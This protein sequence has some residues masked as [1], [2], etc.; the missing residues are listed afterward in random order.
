MSSLSSGTLE[1]RE[2]GPEGSSTPCARLFDLE[3][4]RGLALD[5]PVSHFE[6]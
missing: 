3:E 4:P 1:N 6:L 2:V 5:R